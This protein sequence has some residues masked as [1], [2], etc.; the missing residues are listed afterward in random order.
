MTDIEAGAREQL[1]GLGLRFEWRSLYNWPAV[2]LS[3]QQHINLRRIAREAIA[4]ALKHAHP[5]NIMMEADL[6]K[7]ELGLRISNDG[8]ITEPSIWVP[9]R[10]LNNIKS[11]VAELGGSQ[12]WGIEQ[13]GAN[14][15]YCYLAVRIPLSPSEEHE[16]H[17]ADRRL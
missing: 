5:G 1:A 6:D 9:G 10:G 2:M 12:K 15:R 4:N 16:P 13:Q 17:P 8:A 14:K 7:N 3:S 11:R